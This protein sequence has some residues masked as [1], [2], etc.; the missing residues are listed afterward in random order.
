MIKRIIY[1]FI[2]LL[3]SLMLVEKIRNNVADRFF[4][5]I[6][7]NLG[8][9][10][11]NA[12]L[13]ITSGKI[14]QSIGK[15]EDAKIIYTYIVQ[16]PDLLKQKNVEEQ[17][18]NNLGN[19]FYL[20][21]DYSNAAKAYYLVLKKDPTSREAFLKFI[22]INMA[23]GNTEAIIPLMNSYAARRPTDTTGYTELCAAHTRLGDFI[24]ARK[25]CQMALKHNRNNA[26]AHYDY[27][28]LLEQNNFGADA[29]KELKQAKKI[30]PDIKSRKELEDLLFTYKEQLESSK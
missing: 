30:Q 1:L 21:A 13:L 14:K 3:L 11:N 12:A 27:A 5:P 23:Y 18:Y 17:V 10:N 28:I 15:Y 4:Y 16:H 8:M 29:E 20:L 19:V 22:R 2:L 7:Y 25:N 26:R 9:K 6:V 24:T